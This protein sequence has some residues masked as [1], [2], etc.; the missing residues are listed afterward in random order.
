DQSGQICVRTV[1][2][3]NLPLSLH[4]SSQGLTPAAK[5]LALFGF[6]VGPDDADCADDCAAPAW[7]VVMLIVRVRLRPLRSEVISMPIL[8]RK[9]AIRRTRP[10]SPRGLSGHVL[11]LGST[12]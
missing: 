11:R 2:I 5:P 3:R 8:R 1:R 12:A 9:G 7:V 10:A 4:L 6:E